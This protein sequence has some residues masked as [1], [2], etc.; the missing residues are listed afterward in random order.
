MPALRIGERGVRE[1]DLARV[2]AAR[3]VAL[4]FRARA[5]ERELEAERSIQPAGEVPP[6]GAKCGVRTVIAREDESARRDGRVLHLRRPGA[7][8]QQGAGKEPA[9]LHQSSRTARTGPM[10]MASRPETMAVITAR[11]MRIEMSAPSNA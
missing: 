3:V 11:P 8:R 5:K 9:P 10:P 4:L 7:Y 6:F 2:E 1:Q